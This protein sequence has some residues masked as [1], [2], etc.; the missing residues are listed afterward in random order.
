MKQKIGLLVDSSI[1]WDDEFMKKNDIWIAPLSLTDDTLK[2]YKDDNKDLPRDE[3][4]LRLK[5]G[6]NFK[7]SLTPIGQLIEIL[8][9][10]FKKYDDVVFLPIS[11]GL[12]SQWQSAQILKKE[13]SNLHII[14][15]QSAA[16]T[17]ELIAKDIIN[18]I[19]K[20]K[21]IYEI[22]NSAEA[23]NNNVFSIFS[24]EETSGMKSGGRITKTILHAIDFLKMKPIIRLNVKN[25]YA[26][27]TKNYKK[28]IVKMI[29]ATNKWC[30]DIN[31]KVKLACVYTSGYYQDK[32][33]FIMNSLINAFGILKSN[34]V[35]RW[36]PST[37]LVHTKLGSY[38]FS[39]LAD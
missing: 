26:G 30:K 2:N 4:L 14:D 15:S 11:K 8:E 9:E 16:F 27:V 23:I 35:V 5:N 31:K 10:M 33:D 28:G 37:V 13:Y 22:I 19:K 32:L 20:N 24:V 29:K 7:T 36:I 39:V 25:E 1:T 21:T 38:G 6:D 3:L 17:N 34:I 12:S 18:N